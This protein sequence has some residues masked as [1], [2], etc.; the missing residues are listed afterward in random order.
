MSNAITTP[1]SALE[2][3]SVERTSKAGKTTTRTAIGIAISGN[4]AEKETLAFAMAEEFW[5]DKANIFP[6]VAELN[7][8]FPTLKKTLETRNGDLKELAA[9]NPGT[10]FQEVNLSA[11]KKMDVLAMFVVAR[12][13]TGADKG[14]KAQLLAVMQHI[15]DLE[16]SLAIAKAERTKA[17][18]ASQ[19]TPALTT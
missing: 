5:F 9:Q 2:S 13:L 3:L 7:R 16:D 8:V 17:F 10:K 12:R 19:A 18:Q 6:F 11:P 1:V 14:A 4:K 15:A